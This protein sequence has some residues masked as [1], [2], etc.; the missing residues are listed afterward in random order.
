MAYAR[1][2]RARGEAR[3]RLRQA[4]VFR[5]EGDCRAFCSEVQQLVLAFI[6]DHLNR[7]ASGLTAHERRELLALRGAPAGLLRATDQLLERCDFARFS[8]VATGDAEM[9]ELQAQAEETIVRL[10]EALR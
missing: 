8:S 7:S 10:E 2:R 1:R 4:E 5:E 9:K 3:R 6:A